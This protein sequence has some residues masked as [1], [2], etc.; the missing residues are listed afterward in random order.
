[1]EYSLLSEINK[2]NL[3]AYLSNRGI[4]QYFWPD[5]FPPQITP[6]LD[7]ETLVGS[8]GKPVMADV[9]A[10]NSSA[11]IKRRP[12][13]TTLKGDIPAIRISRPMRETDLNK[14]S[15][16]KAMANTEQKTIM[17]L[18]FDDVKFCF[19]GVKARLEFLALRLLSQSYIGL[20]ATSN[21]GIITTSNIDSQMASANKNCAAVVWTAAV[22]TTTP[23]TD[24]ITA[25]T[26]ARGWGIKLKYALM[27]YTDWGYFQASTQVQNYCF[28]YLYGGTKV[29]LAPTLA[30]ANTMLEGM[31]LPQIILVDQTLIL[32]NQ[33]NT[34]S[35]VTPW[36]T[37]HVLFIPELAVGDMY[38][39]PIAT[40]MNPPKQATLAKQENILIQKYSETNPV[41]EW[42]VG[43]ANAFPSWPS[44]ND[45][46]NLYT[47]H[48]TTWA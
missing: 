40:E 30:I 13:V 4:K 18:V 28:G 5:F 25:Q 33:D 43:E 7:Y 47:L 21:A 23:I 44:V 41:C 46:I 15:I 42:T 1:M 8:E 12:I 35:T 14:Y 32:E 29:R 3:T 45:C 24:F 48:A 17:K 10:Y 19:E 9:V 37:G 11:P 20:S 38:F 16:L 34:Q 26:E 2:K 6:F 36:V 31:G 27:D 22:G 39:G